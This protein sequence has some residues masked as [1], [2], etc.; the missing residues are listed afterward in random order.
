MVVRSNLGLDRHTE[1]TKQHKILW[2]CEKIS[3]FVSRDSGKVFEF[4]DDERLPIVFESNGYREWQQRVRM[5]VRF[6]ADVRR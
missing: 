6:L 3:R 1:A 5:A 4:G 2:T